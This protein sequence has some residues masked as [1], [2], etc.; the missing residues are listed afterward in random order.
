MSN[1]D[2]D[3]ICPEHVLDLPEDDG[4]R[5]LDTER[6]SH[7]ENVVRLDGIHLY[8]GIIS[9]QGEVPEALEVGAICYEL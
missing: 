2:V 5:H 1:V 6:L 4:A 9:A 3:V 8:Y 7:L